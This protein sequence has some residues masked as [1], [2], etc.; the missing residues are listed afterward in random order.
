MIFAKK[1]CSHGEVEDY[2]TS[3]AGE[4]YDGD[5]ATKRLEEDFV[6]LTKCLKDMLDNICPKPMIIRNYRLSASFILDYS[7][8]LTYHLSNDRSKF[9]TTVLPAISIAWIIKDIVKNTYDIIQESNIH[10]HN[11]NIQDSEWLTQYWEESVEEN[12]PETS[13]SQEKILKKGK[14]YY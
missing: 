3:E 11:S 7:P 12:A 13:S 4:T 6:K 2:G 5:Q 1:S 10:N 14:S 8:M 9:G